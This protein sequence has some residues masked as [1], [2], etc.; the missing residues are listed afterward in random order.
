MPR[1]AANCS[2]LFAEQPFLDRFE[3]AAQA[4]FEAVEFLFP[5]AHAAGEIAARLA[6]NG[7]EA[8]LFNAPPGDADAGE[9]GTACIPGREAEFRDGVLRAAEYAQALGVGNVHVMAGLVPAGVAVD[10]ARRTYVD[11]LRFAAAQFAR[12]GVRALI[13]PINRFD[14]PSYFLHRAADALAVIDEVGAPNL[15]LQHDLYHAQRSE[16]ELAA[17]IERL[18]PKIGHMQIADNPGRHEPGS[19]EINFPFL[20]ALIDRLGYRGHIGCEYRPL[21]VTE[22][23]LAWFRAAT[24]A[25]QPA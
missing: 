24:A 3:R 13:E 14:M 25:S 10:V 11:N 6:A 21:A 23:G 12:I 7:L 4:G 2:M 17:N 18:L 19:G 9:R 15:L 20:F 22:A 5:Y 16:G 8:V 1:F